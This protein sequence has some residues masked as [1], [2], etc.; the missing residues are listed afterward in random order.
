M[1]FE[2]REQYSVYEDL[3]YTT[4]TGKGIGK[5]LI[6]YTVSPKNK[7]GS[8]WIEINGVRLK[9]YDYPAE[10]IKEKAVKLYRSFI[11]NKISSRHVVVKEK[12]M[13]R[14]YDIQTGASVLLTYEAVGKLWCLA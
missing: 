1:K 6:K 12:G 11:Q 14:V 3:L 5:I 7:I 9:S 8:T 4:Y 10:S 2:A 13:Y